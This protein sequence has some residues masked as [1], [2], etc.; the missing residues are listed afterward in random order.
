M[1]VPSESKVETWRTR[2]LHGSHRLRWHSPLS[3]YREIFL[4]EEE[5]VNCLVSL[6]NRGKVVVDQKVLGPILEEGPAVADILTYLLSSEIPMCCFLTGPCLFLRWVCMRVAVIREGSPFYTCEVAFLP[7][8]KNC[9]TRRITKLV[10]SCWVCNR[11]AA[12]ESRT[13]KF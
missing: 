2:L 11:I 12:G 8:T 13:T 4:E 6:S 9:A 3:I 7:R 10:N 5:V 1:R